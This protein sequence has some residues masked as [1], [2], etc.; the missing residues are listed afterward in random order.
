MTDEETRPD[1]L[2][3]LEREI[4]ALREEMAARQ[5]RTNREIDLR[6][7]RLRDLSE[8]LRGVRKEL[9]RARRDLGALRRRRAV[10]IAVAL[11]DRVRRTRLAELPIVGAVLRRRGARPHEPEETAARHR[12]R[13]TAA[14]EAALR[15]DLQ[16]KLPTAS[17]RTGPL[18][19]V[20][21]PNRDGERHLRRCIAGLEKLAYRELEVIVVD[22]GSSDGSLR[23]LQ[24]AKPRF[25]L[26]IIANQTN[27]SFSEANNQGAAVAEG[28]LF[29]F[30]NNDIEPFD[31]HAVG[32]IVETILQDDA[33]AAVGALLIYPRRDGP[34]TGPL[35]R[36]ADL[37]VQHRGID[38]AL[39]DGVGRARHPGRGDDP[40]DEAVRAVRDVPAA[41][42]ACLLVRR[43]RFESVG[44]FD[45]DYNYGME[46]VDLCLKL[47]AAGGSIVYDGRAVLW[48]HESATQYQEDS[49]ERRAR[50][51]WNRELFLDRWAPH[52]FRRVFR[53][54]VVGGGKWSEE[55]LRVGITL[56]RDDPAAAWGD[57]YTAHELGDALGAIG[58]EVSYLER[59]E[60]R[61]YEP[62]PATDVIVS[63]LDAFDVRRIPGHIVTV[64][65]IRNW[66]DRW[67]D[68][69]WFDQY[70]IILASSQASAGLVAARGRPSR[71][72]P[73]ATNPER[74]RPARDGAAEAPGD[75]VFT[76]NHWG[77]ERAIARALPEIAA[78]RSV[79]VYGRGWDEV[80]AVGP[81]A[82]GHADYDQLPEIY[83]GAAIVL[84]D[85]AGPTKPYGAVNSRVFDALAAGTLVVT[86]NPV[87]VHELFD[88]EF[89]VVEDPADLP[90]KVES[91]LIDEKGSR[92]LVKRYREIV[93]ERHT[94]E[95]RAR[96]LRQ[97][98]V[99]W[100]EAT[101]V[102]IG[103]GAP[104][105]EVAPSWGDYH[106]G[107]AIQRSLERRGHPAR[108]SLLPEWTARHAAR[109]DIVVHL[110]GL[111]EREIRPSQVSILW[112]ISHPNRVRDEMLAVHDLTFVA[113]DT[114]AAE[115]ATR[116]ERPVIPLHQATDPGRFH[117]TPGGPAHELL[118]V[119]NSR[120]VRR[121]IIDDLTPTTH[122]LAVFGRG[123]T[124]DLLDPR[125][126][127]GEHVPNE[128]LA[129][130]Y[131]AA[132]IV[133][134][135]HWP[136]MAENGF[137]SNRLYD[138][139]A[140]GG[141][142]I[143]DEVD[144]LE[145]EFNGGIVAYRDAAHLRALIEQFLADPD[146]RREHAERARAAVL[147]RHTFDD[148]V[149]ELLRRALPIA[150]ERAAGP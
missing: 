68:Q 78:S 107:R 34:K 42:A 8:E 17:R 29:L 93:L 39:E 122:D 84:D 33:T 49:V 48:H 63:L 40:L 16:A 87:G 65:W 118:F 36:P 134:N 80:P 94:Y 37:T 76:G 59:F 124:P 71:L 131:S 133:L 120:G 95:R 70:D 108:V 96:E 141:F 119:A 128:E 149:D 60:D 126:L 117:P 100:A 38:F 83:R 148:R 110:F 53:D 45:E 57:W 12:V 142:V 143:S 4:A 104:D 3:E 103:V 28:D 115:L 146:G 35:D 92:R 81:F 129:G 144:G 7:D 67:L 74:F 98:L 26:R 52:L 19:S 30:L 62:N 66:T 21:I 5:R 86:D 111:V 91:L 20:V 10:R 137:L 125:H 64:A 132:A 99:D 18:V 112:V 14:E 113:S 75:V 127:L 89:P 105:W 25:P 82:R 88:D 44:G 109:S 31:E 150:A 23:Y 138:A 11:A 41:T 55:P 32:H 46:D 50:Q 27:R 121:R 85:T 114:F 123:W 58:W 73:L 54:K 116:T 147:T 79:A 1:R 135:D 102:E 2:A 72:F 97:I 24:G 47:R 136:D 56:T 9:A 101:R 139:A 61:W 51:D 106:F 77:A 130:Y 140:S 15:T 22:N 6:S 90:A 145:T 69:P 43:D 13:A